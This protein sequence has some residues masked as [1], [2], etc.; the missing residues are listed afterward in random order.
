MLNARFRN[1]V[2]F[3][4]AKYVVF[5]IVLAGF[6]KRWATLVT[7]KSGSTGDGM[8]NGFHYFMYV[9]LVTIVFVALFCLPYYF[10]FKVKNRIVFIVSISLVLL[11]DSYCYMYANSSGNIRDGV[12]HLVVGILI[13]VLFFYKAIR[14][15]LIT[16]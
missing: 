4:F 11:A 6:D 15:K 7:D 12:I 13:L 16:P 9:L 2:L 8:A 5:S 10:V 1:I 14:Q 3:V